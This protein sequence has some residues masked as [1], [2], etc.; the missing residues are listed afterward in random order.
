[1]P[2][3]CNQNN[4]VHYQQ[5][6]SIAVAPHPG[7]IIYFLKNNSNQKKSTQA[8]FK[9]LKAGRVANIFIHYTT[10]I[11]VCF[12]GALVVAAMPITHL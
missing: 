3:Y 10:S 9:G 5:L 12:H 2:A 1:M 4:T 6:I 11:S 8:T 7:K